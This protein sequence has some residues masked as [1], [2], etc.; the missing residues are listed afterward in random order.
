FGGGSHG[1]VI[2][3]PKESGQ[4]PVYVSVT[5]VLTPAQVKQR[6]DEENRLQQEWDAT[7][8]VE[9]AEREYE[10][11]KAE[12]EAEDKKVKGFQTTLN[13][14]KN[15]PEGRALSDA[16]KYPLNSKE[17]RFVAV[18]GYSGGGVHFDVTATVD[19][20]D[21]LNSLINL[22]GAAYVNKVLE[23]GDVT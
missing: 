4:K 23:F 10:R 15:T 7:H 16:G 17:S 14:L 19:S 9:V 13:R 11:A 1:A 6:Q 3:F 18:P 8:P 12:L 5:N 2:R 22:G 20:R 21:R